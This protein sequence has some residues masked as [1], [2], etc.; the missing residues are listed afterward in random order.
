MKR[1]IATLIPALGLAAALCTPAYADDL[2]MM[3]GKWSAKKTN[4][5]GKQYNQQLEIKKNKFT[6]QVKDADG[7]TRLYAEGEVKLDK[8]GPFKTISFTN[9]KA[10]QSSSDA[11]PIDDTYTSI[12]KIG[13]DDTLLVV[14]NF[15]K[16]RDGQKPSLDVYHKAKQAQK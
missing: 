10:G 12:Y 3:A 14:Q 1:H 11:D 9:I 13:E 15:D 16:E 7:D 2:E 4:D 5:E 6:F 8:T